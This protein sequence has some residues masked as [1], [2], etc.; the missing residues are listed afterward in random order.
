MQE[1][2]ENKKDGIVAIG[3]NRVLIVPYES[4]ED[5]D[6]FQIDQFCFEVEISSPSTLSEFKKNKQVKEN[7]KHL[8]QS[9]SGLELVEEDEIVDFKDI[10]VFSSDKLSPSQR[11]LIKKRHNRT[12]KAWRAKKVYESTIKY[13]LPDNYRQYDRSED[14]FEFDTLIGESKGSL[15]RIFPKLYSQFQLSTK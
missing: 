9:S 2:D 11:N 3:D 7:S 12:E 6:A 1:N 5:E 13:G 10:L 8:Y 15:S 4:V 14:N